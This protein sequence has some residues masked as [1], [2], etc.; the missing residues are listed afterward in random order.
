VLAG[1]QG[2]DRPPVVQRVRERDVDGVDVVAG[3]QRL[4]VAEGGRDLERVR[5]RVGRR[6]LPRRDGG[7]PATG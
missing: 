5:E 4:V 2:G 1:Q 7:Q 3:E 6:L